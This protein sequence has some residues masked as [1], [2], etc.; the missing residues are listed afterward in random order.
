M[1]NRHR[2][3]HI[4]RLWGMGIHS[5]G[6]WLVDMLLLIIVLVVV[7]VVVVV[8]EVVAGIEIEAV[9]MDL[10][11]VLFVVVMAVLLDTHN[12]SR[13]NPHAH[14]KIINCHRRNPKRRLWTWPFTPWGCN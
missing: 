5:F 7:V 10:A 12:H 2:H 6:V 4:R 3:N 8:V 9:F 14:N 13:S 1:N 11:G